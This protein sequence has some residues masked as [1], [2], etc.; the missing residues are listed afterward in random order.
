MIKHHVYD[1]PKE[2]LAIR[3]CPKGPQSLIY[4]IPIAELKP[5]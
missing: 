2:L 4:E 3:G 5:I 1:K